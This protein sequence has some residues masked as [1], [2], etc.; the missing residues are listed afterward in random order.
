M[1]SMSLLLS[2]LVLQLAA[3]G[4]GGAWGAA[5]GGVVTGAALRQSGA[6]RTGFLTALGAAALLLLMQALRGAPLLDFADR[7]GG[8]FSLPGWALLLLSMLL[9]A[10][11]SAGFAGGVARLAARPRD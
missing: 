3:Q 1:P 2:A 8:N 5:V 9:P 10:L 7:L 4:V 6:F 11:Q